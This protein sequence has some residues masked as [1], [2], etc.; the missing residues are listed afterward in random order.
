MTGQQARRAESYKLVTVKQYAAEYQVD[1][2]T[3]YRWVESG[4]VRVRRHG[5]RGSIRIV[6]ADRDDD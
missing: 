5:P 2:R 3:V 1:A 6:R 4:A